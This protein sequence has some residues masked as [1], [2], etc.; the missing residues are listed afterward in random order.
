MTKADYP[1]LIF[2]PKNKK[3]KKED[4]ARIMSKSKDARIRFFFFAYEQVLQLLW[5]VLYKEEVSF[6]EFLLEL[7]EFCLRR[8]SKSERLL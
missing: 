5:I 4:E 1:Y 2:V 7:Y 8:N 3:V 6:K